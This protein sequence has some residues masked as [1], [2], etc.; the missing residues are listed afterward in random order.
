MFYIE[1]V[2]S[3]LFATL[4]YVAFVFMVSLALLTTLIA[5]ICDNYKNAAQV[6]LQYWRSEQIIA[7]IKHFKSDLSP[8]NTVIFNPK[9]LHILTTFE[10]EEFN[11]NDSEKRANIPHENNFVNK[12]KTARVQMVV[13][14]WETS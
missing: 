12:L 1:D 6:S 14:I 3:P 7:I 5:S 2:D 8:T 11:E 13:V 4:F 9:W 10:T